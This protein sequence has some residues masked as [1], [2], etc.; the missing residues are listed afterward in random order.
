MLASKDDEKSDVASSVKTSLLDSTAAED[1]ITSID[2]TVMDSNNGAYDHYT[3][4]TDINYLENKPMNHK[5]TAV[6]LWVLQGLQFTLVVIALTA[7]WSKTR[8][9]ND[10][11]NSVIM[12][13]ITSDV[14]SNIEMYADGNA[15]DIVLLIAVFCVFFPVFRFILFAFGTVM[16]TKYLASHNDWPIRS[17][18]QAESIVKEKKERLLMPWWKGVN[19]MKDWFST[20][21]SSMKIGSISVDL[22]VTVGKFSFAQT[23][24]SSLLNNVMAVR[25]DIDAGNDG[26]TITVEIN[27]ETFIGF[28]SY[29]FSMTCTFVM[30]ALLVWQRICWL[31]SYK[32]RAVRGLTSDRENSKVPGESI[33]GSASTTSLA[34]PLLSSSSSND[35]GEFE[36]PSELDYKLA[37]LWCV[38]LS[39]WLAMALGVDLIEVKY[40]GQWNEGMEYDNKASS[41]YELSSGSFTDGHETNPIFRYFMICNWTLL[42]IAVPT[43]TLITIG[44]LVLSK[45]SKNLYNE[46]LY[47]KAYRVL[48]VLFPC[49]THEATFAV[50]VLFII[51]VERVTDPLLN[52]SDNCDEEKCLSIKGQFTSGLLC[53]G[54]YA[55]SVTLTY[56]LLLSHYNYVTYKL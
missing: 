2:D 7:V 15:Y 19:V 36:E 31:R 45:L 5:Y 26:D 11:D 55:M 6:A 51:E 27:S 53:M 54:I 20:K 25:F 29:G 37:A 39:S 24:L 28:V 22:L 4:V 41:F 17:T 40:S 1:S 18:E 30:I 38:S 44:Y 13:L 21:E 49:S 56:R 33:Y 3:D 8:L 35:S 34:E 46:R 50:M 48:R 52:D 42:A 10:D 47:N 16:H 12:E 32:E 14:K 43:L 23:V 9:Y